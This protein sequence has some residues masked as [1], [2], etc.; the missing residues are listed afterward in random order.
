MPNE[1]QSPAPHNDTIRALKH[2]ETAGLQAFVRNENN[3]AA[4]WNEHS[5]SDNIGGVPASPGAQELIHKAAERKEA[6]AAA[7]LDDVRATIAAINDDPARAAEAATAG[8]KT[9]FNPSKAHVMGDAAKPERDAMARLS[10]QGKKGGVRH[11]VLQVMAGAQERH[12]AKQ[13]NDDPTARVDETGLEYNRVQRRGG[14]VWERAVKW[15]GGAEK[16]KS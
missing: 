13:Y 1:V 2:Q 6:R 15:L 3:E 4:Y 5:E 12:A 16:P 7:A 9:V 8:G 14:G 10:A 11:R